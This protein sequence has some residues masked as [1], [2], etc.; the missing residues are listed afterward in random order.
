MHAFNMG[1]VITISE[2]AYNLLVREKEPKESFSKLI[3]RH[4]GEKN[5][6]EI[7][8]LAGVWKNKPDLIKVMRDIYKDRK[9]FKLR[10]VKLG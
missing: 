9:N 1:K 6:N 4:F 10:D 8:N 7:M 3:V 5:K 2:D